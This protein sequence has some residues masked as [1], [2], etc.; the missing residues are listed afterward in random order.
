MPFRPGWPPGPDGWLLAV[1]L[2]GLAAFMA[3]FFRDPD[4]TAPAL[5]AILAPADGQVVDVRA[6]GEDPSWGP[7]RRCR[8]SSRRW[9]HINRAPLAGLVVDVQYRPGAKMAAYRPE[10]SE[11][12]RAHGHLHPGEAGR[13]VVRQI[14]G[15]WRAASF[16][17]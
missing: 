16:A 17:G 4:R 3:F 1:L 15:C 8:S 5:Q 10:A 11:R 2:A 12:E 9:T 13:V 7:P 14:A 6:T